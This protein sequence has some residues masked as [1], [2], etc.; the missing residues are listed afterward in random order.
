M[1]EPT[2]TKRFVLDAL[3]ICNIKCKFCYYLHSY[4]KWSEY[5]WN[6][7]KCKEEI[8][9]GITRGNNYMEITGG[10]PTIH[11]QICEIIKYALD[12]G[13]RTC[14]ITNG[15][16]SE[17]KARQI[18]DAGI[19]DF[20][21]SR[22]GLK[23]THNF[24]TNLDRAYDIQIRFLSQ[25][26]G[27]MKF[28]FNC[29][30]NRFNQSE[31]FGIAKKLAYWQ[32]RI[33]NFIN[34]NPHHEW[35]DK[36]LET[37]QVIADLS[38]VQPL[39][40]KSIEYLESL[41]IGVNL[42][43]YPMCCIKEEYRRTVCNDLHVVFDPHEWDYHIQPK[44]YET[45]RQWGINTSRNVEHKEAPCCHCDLQWI[46]GGINKAYFNASGGKFIRDI[47]NLNI[48]VPFNGESSKNDFYFYRRDNFLT[49]VEKSIQKDREIKNNVTM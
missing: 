5:L 16:V 15:I 10:E 47:E 40:E 21:V 44:T 12:R 2:P 35:Q 32:P 8:D 13:V 29:V 31:I 28:R 20:L 11:P 46:C 37:S 26:R 7:D 24:I 3:R 6:L 33:V 27:K 9:K 49:L 14:I 45:F 25:I 39:L 4:E 36:A 48:S 43:Y 38:I 34:M 19:D 22:H 41:G 18:L 17:N 1:I 30:I 23:D 42:R